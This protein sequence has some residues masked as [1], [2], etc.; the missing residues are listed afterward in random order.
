MAVAAGSSVL[1]TMLRDSLLRSAGVDC[2]KDF[3]MK[4]M[5]FATVAAVAALS[6][7]MQPASAAT[8][9][10]RP[11]DD[12]NRQQLAQYEQ[13]M[14]NRQSGPVATAQPTVVYAESDAQTSDEPIQ[15]LVVGPA[16][17]V[18]ESSPQPDR[19]PQSAG[20]PSIETPY[21]AIVRAQ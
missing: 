14:A 1:F 16:H 8:T 7:A 4:A 5:T 9:K 12:L 10:A 3:D 13:D 17:T 19:S 18:R 11:S 2:N 6:L 20:Q 21:I 15:V